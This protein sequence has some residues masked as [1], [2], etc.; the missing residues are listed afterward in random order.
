M[1]FLKHIRKF[2]HSPIRKSV[3]ARVWYKYMTPI[4]SSISYPNLTPNSNCIK[5]KNGKIIS[6]I[7]YYCYCCE[8]TP[9][10]P[11]DFECGHVIARCKRD[12]TNDLE[13]LRPICTLCNRSM[14]TEN[15]YDFKKSITEKKILKTKM[16]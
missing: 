1:N 4:I 10:T 14:R 12:S 8:T 16:V 7:D 3:R 11:F 9:I 2:S 15:L 6:K 13:N 5:D